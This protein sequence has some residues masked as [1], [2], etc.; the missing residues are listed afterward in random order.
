MVRGKYTK[1]SK[2]QVPAYQTNAQNNGSLK[3]VYCRNSEESLA[4]KKSLV[5]CGRGF[6]YLNNKEMIVEQTTGT[7]IINFN[8][9]PKNR[10]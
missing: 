2:K 3:S 10:I 1:T 6:L 8:P 5:I 7:K 9:P 4:Q